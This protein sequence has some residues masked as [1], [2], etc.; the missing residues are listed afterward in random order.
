M[1]PTP[2]QPVR[3]PKLGITLFISPQSSRKHELSGKLLAAEAHGHRP[4]FQYVVICSKLFAVRSGRT[5]GGQNLIA[6]WKHIRFSHRRR[7]ELFLQSLLDLIE[8][9]RLSR[10]VRNAR[11]AHRSSTRNEES[12]L[13]GP[14]ITGMGEPGTDSVS[15]RHLMLQTIGWTTRWPT[16]LAQEGKIFLSYH[17]RPLDCAPN[18]LPGTSA[19]H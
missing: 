12:M 11:A 10:F 8:A 18:L 9:A 6:T 15:D 2:M 16:V 13:T 5:V 4:N 3:A 19:I 1:H 17:G 7:T 14:V